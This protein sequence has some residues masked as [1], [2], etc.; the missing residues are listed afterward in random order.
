MLRCIRPLN[1][2]HREVITFLSVYFHCTQFLHVR[3]HTG[4]VTGICFATFTQAQEFGSL[5]DIVATMC[6]SLKAASWTVTLPVLPSSG[7]KVPE[8]SGNQALSAT[9]SKLLQTE[10]TMKNRHFVQK[11]HPDYGASSD[12]NS[13]KLLMLTPSCK[14]WRTISLLTPT[15]ASNTTAGLVIM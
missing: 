5:E 15:T 1:L 4:F 10:R 2:A 14:I 13:A 11:S 7:P 6:A 3:D 12:A 8:P 9:N